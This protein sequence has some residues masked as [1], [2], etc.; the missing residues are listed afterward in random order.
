MDRFIGRAHFWICSS[1]QQIA[2]ESRNSTELFLP[3][4]YWHS[5]GGSVALFT[6]KS[7]VVPKGKKTFIAL[8][9][10]GL[11]GALLQFFEFKGVDL[12]LPPATVTFIMFSYPVWI[13]VANLLSR[14]GSVDITEGVQ[15]LAVVA[16]IYLIGHSEIETL[17]LDSEALLYPLLASVFIATWIL[18]SN[19]LRKEGVGPF[20]LSAYYDLF[21]FLALTL[22]FSGRWEQDWSQFLVWSLAP[23]HIFG[24]F[25]FSAFVGL[26]PNFLF[27]FGSSKVSSHFAATILAL[28]PIFSSLYSAALWPTVFGSNFV[29]GATLILL[30]NLPKELFAFVIQ[31]LP[32]KNKIVFKRFSKEMR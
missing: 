12:G 2:S 29:V 18:L 27:Y 26:L 7:E 25:I 4:L 6:Q 22:I 16:G 3:T 10:I 9:A 1:R 14:K 11:V 8:I 13:L 31:K 17:K 15:S 30:A 28:E 21:S 5:L 32:M 20:Q 24:M 23:H 19:H